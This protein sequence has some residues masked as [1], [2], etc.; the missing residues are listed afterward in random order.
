[1]PRCFLLRGWLAIRMCGAHDARA[2]AVV[3]TIENIATNMRGGGED[4]IALMALGAE[5]TRA[6]VQTSSCAAGILANLEIA[7]GSPQADL[8]DVR[9]R[10]CEA[11]FRSPGTVSEGRRQA[12]VRYN[13]AWL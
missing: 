2:P 5:S 12:C 11:Q 6:T 8:S 9:S 3:Q 7:P 4:S 10:S 1:M 13:R